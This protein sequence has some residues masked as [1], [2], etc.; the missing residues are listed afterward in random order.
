MGIDGSTSTNTYNNQ[1]QHGENR[2]RT[3]NN[4]TT[5]KRKIKQVMNIFG[6]SVYIDNTEKVI[7]L[8]VTRS[9]QE[10]EQGDGSDDRLHCNANR[11]SY[12]TKL[13]QVACQLSIQ[14]RAR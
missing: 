14:S 5:L 7:R 6:F 11:G 10:L 1:K 4:S 2:S 9:K 3:R 8:Q 13:K 12:G